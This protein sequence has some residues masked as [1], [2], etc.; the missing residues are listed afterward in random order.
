MNYIKPMFIKQVEKSICSAKTQKK[1]NIILRGGLNAF[2]YCMKTK[3]QTMTYRV[4]LTSRTLTLD[5][6][7]VNSVSV[8]RLLYG[9]PRHSSLSNRICY[10]RKLFV[11][12]LTAR[13]NK[14][15][16]LAHNSCRS[17]TTPWIEWSELFHSVVFMKLINFMF[18][19]LKNVIF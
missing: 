3:G 12:A 8:G 4:T 16:W 10:Q 9:S 19:N 14:D 5:P 7:V 13:V 15:N 11:S 2:F 17:H 1:Q 6:H 18:M